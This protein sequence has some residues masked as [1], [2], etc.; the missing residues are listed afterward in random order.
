MK[1]E[2]RTGGGKGGIRGKKGATKG[3]GGTGI[4]GEERRNGIIEVISTGHGDGR[5]EE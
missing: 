5:K 2:G 1:G 3:G 4:E